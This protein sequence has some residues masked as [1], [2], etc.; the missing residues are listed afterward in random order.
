MSNQQEFP[1]PARVGGKLL[2]DRH[3]VENHKRGLIGLESLKREPSVPISFVT[4]QQ[5]AVELQMDRR[6]LGRRI[7]GRVRGEEAQSQR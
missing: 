3:E 5:I 6:T 2:F 7:R 4:A 1:T